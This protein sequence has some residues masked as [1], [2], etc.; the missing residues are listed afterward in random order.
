MKKIG[1]KISKGVQLNQK[2]IT[3][4]KLFIFKIK[5]NFL[6]DKNQKEQKKSQETLTG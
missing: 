5:K 6:K 4:V 1:R 2:A 3:V